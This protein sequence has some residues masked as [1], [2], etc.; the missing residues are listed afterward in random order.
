MAT[1]A[2]SGQGAGQAGL[3]GSDRVDRRIRRVQE[4]DIT[5]V[6][7]LV[8]DLAE[9]EGL[10]HEC[11][12]TD[13]RLRAALFGPAAA[14]FGHVAEVDGEIAGCALWFLSF[15]TFRGTHGIYL[16]DLF[17]RPDRRGDGLGR[18]LLA[19]LAQECVRRGYSRL[20]WSVLDWNE[21]AIGFYTSL[22]AG[23]HDGWTVFRLT[24]DALTALG[25]GGART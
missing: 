7:E 16:E 14:V 21:Q 2:E 8:R 13:D 15:S 11:E 1:L 10:S 23:P 19:E 3:E 17:V 25:T 18:A 20:E 6:V 24:D 5:A 12:M 9:F 22:G 4:T